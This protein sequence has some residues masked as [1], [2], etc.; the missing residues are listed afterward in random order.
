MG[1]IDKDLQEIIDVVAEGVQTGIKQLDNGFQYTDIFAF[2]P[3]LGKIPEAIEDAEN[4]LHY[5]KD[6]D[7][8]KEN[9]IVDAVV[10][11]LQDSSDKVKM[12]ARRILRLL[13][14]GYMA[15]TFFAGMKAA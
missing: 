4:A 3:V 14:E 10:A 11:K 15:A 13:A 12:A 1:N 2:V 8:Q 7:E 5:L 9:D 6:M